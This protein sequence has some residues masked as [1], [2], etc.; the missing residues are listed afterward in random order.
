M[1]ALSSPAAVISGHACAAMHCFHSPTVTAY[2]PIAKGR[3]LTRCVGRSDAS[4]L[5]PIMKAPP[6]SSTVSGALG[7]A[8]LGGGVAAA[9]R[10]SFASGCASGG[11][12][13]TVAPLGVGVGEEATGGLGSAPVPVHQE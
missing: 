2:L 12:R 13:T 3:R 11:A 5:L 6:G 10:S 8:G 9:R 4:S 1:G 7:G